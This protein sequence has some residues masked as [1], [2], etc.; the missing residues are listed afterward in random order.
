[1]FIGVLIGAIVGGL[2]NIFVN[3]RYRPLVG[4]W[5][6]TV[7]PEERLWGAMMAGPSLVFGLFFLGWTGAYPSVPWYIPAGSTI[8]LGMSFSLVFISL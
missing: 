4:L 2:M 5:K 7:P 3:E 8:S 6:G 1:M